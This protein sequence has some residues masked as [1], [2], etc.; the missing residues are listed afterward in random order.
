MSATRIRSRLLE[1][2]RRIEVALGPELH[3]IAAELKVRLGANPSKRD[4]E[5]RVDALLNE[6]LPDHDDCTARRARALFRQA[7]AKELSLQ[8]RQSQSAPASVC[9]ITP[10]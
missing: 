2:Q 6:V 3:I 4:V 9:H 7:L 1:A 5:E 8:T 10:N